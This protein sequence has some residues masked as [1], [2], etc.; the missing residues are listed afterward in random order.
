MTG[1][2]RPVH[3]DDAPSLRLGY[4]KYILFLTM[5]GWSRWHLILVDL[6]LL[7]SKYLGLNA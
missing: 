4:R 2:Q 7:G 3:L 5:I 1:P 6:L